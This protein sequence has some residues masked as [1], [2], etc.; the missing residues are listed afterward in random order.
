MQNDI[1]LGHLTHIPKKIKN[2]MVL[3]LLLWLFLDSFEFYVLVMVN[4]QN[5]L[6]SWSFHT[7]FWQ[8]HFKHIKK[9]K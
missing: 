4:S 8:N 7:F 9:Y 6:F 3:N 1:L 5:K 2:I